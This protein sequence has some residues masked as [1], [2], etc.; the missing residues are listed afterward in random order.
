MGTNGY[1][2]L[3]GSSVHGISQTT[4]LEWVAIPFPRESSDPG[5]EPASLVSPAL[6]DRFFTTSTTWEAHR[7][8]RYTLPYI[9]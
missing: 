1:C 7:S 2:S 4:M 9:K 8:L 5:I 3:P 6:A